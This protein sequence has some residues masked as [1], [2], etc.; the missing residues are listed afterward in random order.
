MDEY[1][2]ELRVVSNLAGKS[3]FL[4]QATIGRLADRSRRQTSSLTEACK[5]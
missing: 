1:G 2:Y 4:R 3:W 5:T